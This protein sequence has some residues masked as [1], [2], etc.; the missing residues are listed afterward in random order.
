ME[1]TDAAIREEELQAALKAINLTI[2]ADSKLCREYI[3]H[4]ESCLPLS[5][6]V[7]KM[8]EAHFLHNYTRYQKTMNRIK[9]DS[10]C[11]CSDTD[12]D[13]CECDYVSW[14]E[15]A[16][17][18]RARVLTAVRGFPEEWPWLCKDYKNNRE[19]KEKWLKRHKAK[20][21]ESKCD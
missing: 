15:A 18:A 20:R 7:Q 1:C 16:A 19:W 13:D 14:T 6:I 9:A 21:V 17:T 8:A 12:S 5:E 2:R 11:Y 4:P 3:N 10:V